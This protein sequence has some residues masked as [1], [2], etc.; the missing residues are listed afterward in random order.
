M[1]S[2]A[3]IAAVEP[4]LR[5]VDERGLFRSDDNARAAGES[6]EHEYAALGIPWLP[7]QPRERPPKTGAGAAA[8]VPVVM[9]V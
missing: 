2:N 7:P 1:V 8:A 9:E 3:D 5:N 4:G 6:D